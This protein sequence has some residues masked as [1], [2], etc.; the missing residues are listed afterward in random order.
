MSYIDFSTIRSLFRDRI[1]WSAWE[2]LI[3][4]GGVEI[5]RPRESRHP[6][7]P[8]IIYP[9]DYGFLPGTIGT[10]GEGV[11]VFIGTASSGL[12]GAI[13]TVDLRRGDQ[14]V[15]FLFNCTRAEIYLVNG[16]I[17]YAPD[18]MYGS[19]VVRRPLQELH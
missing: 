5:D 15:K 8:E 2:D 19:L 18:K 1:H 12:V 16:F 13:L 3:H 10:D 4:R 9:I 6:T 7:F 17:N 14:E 11:D